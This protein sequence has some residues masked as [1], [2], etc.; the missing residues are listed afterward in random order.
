MVALISSQTW[1]QVSE[2]KKLERA[3]VDLKA[4]LT[5]LLNGTRQVSMVHSV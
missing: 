1:T 3:E 2:E 4:D 5:A